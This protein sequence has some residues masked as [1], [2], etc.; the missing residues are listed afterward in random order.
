MTS[1]WKDKIICSSTNQ[2]P[3]FSF[4]ST[5]G[6]VSLVKI[7]SNQCSNYIVISNSKQSFVVYKESVQHGLHVLNALSNGIYVF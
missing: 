1:L 6:V 7:D 4:L 3:A 5:W 2:A